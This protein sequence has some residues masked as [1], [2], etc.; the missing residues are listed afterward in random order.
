MFLTITDVCCG[1]MSINLYESL[2]KGEPVYILIFK[3]IC[4]AMR[5]VLTGN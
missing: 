1:S 4:E 3:H 2:L 5:T